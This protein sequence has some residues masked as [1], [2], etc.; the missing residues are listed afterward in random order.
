MRPDRRIKHPPKANGSL[1][2]SDLTL[3]HDP[4]PPRPRRLVRAAEPEAGLRIAPHPG[5][6]EMK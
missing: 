3:S 4:L 5:G 2:F 6:N 1:L